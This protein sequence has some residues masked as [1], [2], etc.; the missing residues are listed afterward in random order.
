[1]PKKK[2]LTYTSLLDNRDIQRGYERAL[3]TVQG[4]LGKHHPMSIGG[5]RVAAVED[6]ETRSPIDN[7]IVIGTFQK[8]GETAAKSAV[9]E[10]KE[11]FP[12]WSQ[13]DWAERVRITRIVADRLE[14]DGALLA[15]L[16]TYEVGKTGPRPLLRYVKR[17]KC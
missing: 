3:E 13:T 16:M 14:R 9:F 11:A 5:R 17:S 7:D 4:E 2:K 8:G 10:A 15:A 6:F 1:M 12:E